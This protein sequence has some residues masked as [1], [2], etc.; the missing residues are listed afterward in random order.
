LKRGYFIVFE[1]PDGS[2]KSTQT[3]LLYNRLRAEG[4]SCV[5][6]QEPGGTPEGERIRDILL[7]PEFSLCPKAE[8][9]LFVADRAEHVHRIIEPSLNEGKIVICSR[10]FYSTLV[11]QGYARKIADIDFLRK[12]NLFAVN[13]I[14][15]DIIFYLDTFAEKGLHKAQQSSYE[16]YNFTGG[17]RIEKEGVEFHELVREGYLEL[18]NEYREKFVIINAEKTIE[19]IEAAIYKTLKRRLNNDRN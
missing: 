2:G 19:E 7:K 6:T 14:E 18:A 17:D 9:F 1:G 11:Y 16:K 10:Y 12:I 3:K 13:N 5:I 4:Y 15:P 8:L